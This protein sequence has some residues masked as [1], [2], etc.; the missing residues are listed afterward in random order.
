ME[1]FFVYEMKK[2]VGLA[3][4]AKEILFGI[5]KFYIS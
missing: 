3:P 5:I 2:L 4:D 1:K